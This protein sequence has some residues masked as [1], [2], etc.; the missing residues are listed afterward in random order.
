MD[1]DE[2]A[3]LIDWEF[4]GDHEA[5]TTASSGDLSSEAEESGSSFYTCDEFSSDGEAS[6]TSEDLGRCLLLGRWTNNSVA[7]YRRARLDR[8]EDWRGFTW[9]ERLLRIALQA[10]VDLLEEKI[11]SENDDHLRSREP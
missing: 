8:W 1:L 10:L 7:R 2:L 9:Q 6:V 3:A 5:S 11:R 4:L